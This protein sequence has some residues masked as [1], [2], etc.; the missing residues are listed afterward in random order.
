MRLKNLETHDWKV[1]IL[2]NYSCSYVEKVFKLDH[3]DD[4][5]EYETKEVRKSTMRHAI[6]GPWAMVIHLWDASATGSGLFHLTPRFSNL[7]F[8]RSC[9]GVLVVV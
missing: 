4:R 7:T 1:A 5:V 9:S 6:G 8:R 2:P 3:R